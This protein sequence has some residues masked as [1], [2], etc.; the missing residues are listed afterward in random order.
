[1]TYQRWFQLFAV[2]L[3]FGGGVAAGQPLVSIGVKG[4]IPITDPEVAHDESRRY[5]V[6]PSVE[7]RLPGRFAIEVDALYQRV[8]NSTSYFNFAN[9]LL[10]SS[11]RGNQWQF[12][13]LGKYYFQPRTSSWQPYVG[14]GY[15]LRTTW[16]T[17]EG[18][19][20]GTDQN[21]NPTPVSYKYTSRTNVDFGGEFAAGV[22]FKAGR[23]NISPEFRYTRW[24]AQSGLFPKNEVK[25]LVGIS[26]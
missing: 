21:S 12:P 11:N 3:C 1:M 4:G 8:G 23:V 16:L 18:I 15:S 2:A 20:I 19:S 14:A 24:G 25:F 9:S 13:I 22:R 17:T 6:G 7:V 10:Q 26:F 5:I